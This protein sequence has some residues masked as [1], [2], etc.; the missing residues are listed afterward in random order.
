MQENT[1]HLKKQETIGLKTKME[2]IQ[3]KVPKSMWK[4]VKDIS[5]NNS[6]LFEDEND[7]IIHALTDLLEYYGMKEDSNGQTH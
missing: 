5:C 6:D 3:I 7:V 1:G 2:T 4:K